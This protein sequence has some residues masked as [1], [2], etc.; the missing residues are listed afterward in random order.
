LRIKEYIK[1]YIT[2]HDSEHDVIEILENID[3]E[4]DLDGGTPLNHA[5]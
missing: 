4:I 5:S 1:L 3:T 2:G